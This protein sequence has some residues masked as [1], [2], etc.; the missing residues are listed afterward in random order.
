MYAYN[1]D[2]RTSDN[3]AG[4]AFRAASV[5]VPRDVKAKLLGANTVKGPA[6]GKM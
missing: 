1:T 2:W 5:G 4:L 3:W 6:Q